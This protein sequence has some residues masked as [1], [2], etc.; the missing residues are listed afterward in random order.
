MFFFFLV[1]FE[2]S[3]IGLLLIENLFFLVTVTSFCAAVATSLLTFQSNIAI[4]Y[5]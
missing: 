4:V 5:H 3:V 1:G 2:I